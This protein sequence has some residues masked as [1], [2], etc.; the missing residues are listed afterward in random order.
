MK[1]FIAMLTL[2]IGFNANAGLLTIDLST[3]EVAV[4]DSV[5]VTIN[6]SGFAE[7]DNF[8]FDFGFDNSVMS[9]DASSLSSG[10]T[11]GDD[12]NDWNGLEVRPVD[13]ILE[14]EFASDDTSIMASGD[15][16]LASFYLIADVA[17][18][19]VLSM[20]DLYGPGDYTI[21]FSGA[22]SINVST[23]AVPEPSTVFMM[24]LAGFALVSTRRKAK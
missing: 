14:M 23:V 24:M 19:T 17:G 20:A 8:W 5:L 10:L 11:L 12:T 18:S 2:L 15:F 3:D 21:N 13:S 1:K 9:Y 6:A 22:D 7:T 4:G 16:V